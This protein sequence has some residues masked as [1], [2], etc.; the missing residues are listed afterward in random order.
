MWN[1]WAELKRTN[2]N[3][4]GFHSYLN[5]YVR[6]NHPNIYKLIELLKKN[7]ST[8]LTNIKRAETG[9]R[10]KQK[11]QERNKDLTIEI[12]KEQYRQDSN[13]EQLFSAMTFQVQ[14]PY[15]SS[16][17]DENPDYVDESKK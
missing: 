13:F 15:H 10:P 11:T 2:N 5:Q 8:T 7:H 17:D 4:E 9:F 1:F 16:W 14:F 3:I 12:I 6:S